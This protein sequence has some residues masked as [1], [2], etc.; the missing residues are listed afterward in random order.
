MRVEL[1][2][3]GRYK[4]NESFPFKSWD[5][6]YYHVRKHLASRTISID[7]NK[8]ETVGIVRVSGFRTVGVVLLL[9]DL[10]PEHVA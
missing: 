4:A 5:D 1:V 9:E 10:P 2:G 6:I 7:W 8:A 3:I